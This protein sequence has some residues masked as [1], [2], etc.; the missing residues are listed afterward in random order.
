MLIG[1][2]FFMNE[3]LER[4]VNPPY[5]DLFPPIVFRIFYI[6]IGIAL[7]IYVLRGVFMYFYRKIRKPELAEKKAVIRC[8]MCKRPL[9]KRRLITLIVHHERQRK[10]IVYRGIICE[11]CEDSYI[12]ISEQNY[13]VRCEYREFGFEDENNGEIERGRGNLDNE[14]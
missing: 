8:A 4:G 3:Y 5:F 1:S 7:G 9:R 2:V 10:L 13:G 12:K 14:Q 11:R 6:L